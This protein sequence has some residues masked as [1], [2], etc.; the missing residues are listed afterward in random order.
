MNLIMIVGVAE[1]D[2]GIGWSSL[3]GLEDWWN[4]GNIPF[5]FRLSDSYEVTNHPPPKNKL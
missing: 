2:I 3:D 5:D 1:S 4:D